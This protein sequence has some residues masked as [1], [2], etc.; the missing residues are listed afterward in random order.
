MV[1]PV[2]GPKFNI[3]QKGKLACYKQDLLAHRDGQGFRQNADTVGMSPQLSSFPHVDVQGTLE[4]MET[5]ILNSGAYVS[6]GDG[7]NS[8]G[9][10]NIGDPG[11]ATIETAFSAAF[12]TLRI[13][14]RGGVV[15]LKTG[16]Y[17]FATSVFLPAGVSV[18]GELGGTLLSA[19]STN[20]IFVIS[21]SESETVKASP[22]LTA[23]GS[24]QNKLYNLT[25]FDS[26]GGITPNLHLSSLIYCE[27][28]S[29]LFIEQC[30]MFGNIAITGSPPN[31]SKYVVSYN[32]GT[33]STL[34]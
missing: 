10:F 18:I 27:R 19:G 33:T 13:S 31:V 30:S 22:V 11:I 2:S 17:E 25:F 23:D 32:T 4:A 12:A 24:K 26:F 20:P 14:F 29:N 21:E 9:T 34:N 1:N 5:F 3:Q 28:G 16:S 15:Q 7:V 6:I 8:F